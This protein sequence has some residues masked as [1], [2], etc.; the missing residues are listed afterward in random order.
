[1][2]K[3]SLKRS[4]I[5]AELQSLF[6]VE[7]EV[8]EVINFKL[9]Y[10]NSNPYWLLEEKYQTPWHLETWPLTNLK[11]RIAYCLSRLFPKLYYRF[12]SKVAQ[13]SVT[14]GSLY[15]ELA[16]KYD[17]LG[18]FLG[19]PGPNSKIVIFANLGDENFFIKVPINENSRK[20]IFNEANALSKLANDT[21]LSSMIPGHYW[22]RDALICEDM[23]AKGGKFRL[24]S[25]TTLFDVHSRLFEHS[26]LPLDFEEYAKQWSF[27]NKVKDADVDSLNCKISAAQNAVERFVSSNH[28]ASDIWCYHAHGDFTPWNVLRAKDGTPRI[29]DWELYGL[30]P[31]YF[32]VF[33]YRVSY[34]ILVLKLSSNKIFTNIEK[35]ASQFLDK[36]SFKFYFGC[37]LAVQMSTYSLV[38]YNQRSIHKQAFWQLDKWAELMEIL[39][40]NH[41]NKLELVSL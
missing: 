21:V 20:L 26:N 8:C 18:V 33:H 37:Y 15:A 19:T 34:E 6:Q 2:K 27:P 36:H 12:C 25:N 11:A 1:M 4:F 35:M 14:K 38:F 17:G 28:D 29:I 40:S 32:D 13:I 39:I 10:K 16:Q 5:N 31:K 30:K 23:R 41:E 9:F 24:L 7:G 3:K 22:I